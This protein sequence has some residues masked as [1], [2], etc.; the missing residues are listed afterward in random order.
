MA[1]PFRRSLHHSYP[2]LNCGRNMGIFVYPAYLQRLYRFWRCSPA[3]PPVTNPS[4]IFRNILSSLLDATEESLGMKLNTSS[5]FYGGGK[6]YLP[7]SAPWELNHTFS[8]HMR[9]AMGSLG[10]SI[11]IGDYSLFPRPSVSWTTHWNDEQDYTGPNATE[12]PFQ[13]AKDE[14]EMREYSYEGRYGTCGTRRVAEW[15]REV[16]KMKKNGLGLSR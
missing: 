13:H 14:A 11:E 2:D 15:T 8:L 4:P 6:I 5:S 10:L 16:E 9:Q 12:L 1:N 3:P 7:I